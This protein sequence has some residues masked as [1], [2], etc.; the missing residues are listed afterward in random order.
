LSDTLEKKKI[1]TKGINK[2]VLCIGSR[3][4]LYEAWTSTAKTYATIDD[5]LMLDSSASDYNSS[6]VDETYFKD[7]SNKSFVSRLSG[8]FIPSH[9]SSYR[10]Y[11]KCDDYAVLYFS[12]SDNATAKVRKK[13]VLKH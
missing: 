9:N 10:F 13:S 7:S 3:G 12:T 5:V 8:L 11:I 1:D 4:L 2:E 6:L